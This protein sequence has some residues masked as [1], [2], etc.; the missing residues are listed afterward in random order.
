MNI[1]VDIINN[2]LEYRGFGITEL[3]ILINIIK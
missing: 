1:K 2:E 3:R